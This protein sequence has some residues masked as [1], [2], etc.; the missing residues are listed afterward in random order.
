M[1]YPT[2]L[3]L[4]APYMMHLHFAPVSHYCIS[5]F[6]ILFFFIT[7]ALHHSQLERQTRYTP[8]TH[9]PSHQLPLLLHLRLGLPYYT[10]VSCPSSISYLLRTL[11]YLPLLS[12]TL[13]QIKF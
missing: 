11:L 3:D 10:P 9:S 8:N 12:P 2:G 4:I 6:W 13:D 7:L 1:K 5:C